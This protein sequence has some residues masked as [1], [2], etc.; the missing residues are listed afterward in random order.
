MSVAPERPRAAHNIAETRFLSESDV[1]AGNAG[2]LSHR[3]SRRG[4][5]PL[6]NWARGM[7]Q[8]DTVG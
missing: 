6:V 2:F 7:A 5:T 4:M 3:L 8:A 1:L